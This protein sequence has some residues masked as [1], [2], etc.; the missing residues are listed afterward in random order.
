MGDIAG[1]TD[2]TDSNGCGQ[3]RPRSKAISGFRFAGPALA[4][5]GTAAGAQLCYIELL[6]FARKW[7]FQAE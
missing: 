6:R 3:Q 5:A 4:R 1:R 7:V 2:A